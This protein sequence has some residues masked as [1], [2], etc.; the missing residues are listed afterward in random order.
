MLLQR[1]A[2]DVPPEELQIVSYHPGGVFTE[3]AE[4]A[5]FSQNDPRLDEGMSAFFCACF[6]EA[7]STP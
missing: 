5:G 1:I 2:K 6:K 3:L 4:Q 7:A